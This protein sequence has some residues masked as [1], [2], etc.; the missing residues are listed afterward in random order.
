M[1][2]LSSFKERSSVDQ[3]WFYL[4]S[5]FEGTCENTNVKEFWVLKEKH[6]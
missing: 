2:N 3:I 6:F 4:N 1:C 5:V